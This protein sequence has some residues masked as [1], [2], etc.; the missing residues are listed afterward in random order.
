MA[1]KIIE[2]QN[3]KVSIANLRVRKGGMI[4]AGHIFT[5][6]NDIYKKE[7]LSDFCAITRTIEE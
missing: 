7:S 6:E 5:L 2:V 3:V 4:D 1:N